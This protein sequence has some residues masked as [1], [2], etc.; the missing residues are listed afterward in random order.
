MYSKTFDSYRMGASIMM[1]FLLENIEVKMSFKIYQ[2]M[3]RP[4]LEVSCLL[5]G[6]F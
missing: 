2:K 6:A 5:K 1:R 4:I 3:S